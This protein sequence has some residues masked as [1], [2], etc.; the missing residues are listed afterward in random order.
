MVRSGFMWKLNANFIYSFT[1]LKE[2]LKLGA[3]MENRKIT[4]TLQLIIASCEKTIKETWSGHELYVEIFYM[5][6]VLEQVI[7][8]LKILK[9]QLTK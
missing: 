4:D 2:K 5:F 8:D 3:A 6:N 1:N 9:K 7:R